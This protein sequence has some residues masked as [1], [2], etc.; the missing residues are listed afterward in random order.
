MEHLVCI[1]SGGM[2]DDN[3]EFKSMRPTITI[4]AS[5]M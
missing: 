5:L 4:Y 2:V 1:F 3:E